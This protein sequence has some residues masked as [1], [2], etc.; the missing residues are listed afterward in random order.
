[1]FWFLE[2]SDNINF[3]SKYLIM[4]PPLLQTIKLLSKHLYLFDKKFLEEIKNINY[5]KCISLMMSFK[6]GNKY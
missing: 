5:H 2:G 6:K 1:M 3:S 4:T